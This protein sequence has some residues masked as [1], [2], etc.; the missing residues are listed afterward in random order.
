MEGDP[1]IGA[2]SKITLISRWLGFKAPCYSDTQGSGTGPV[3]L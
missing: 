3:P 2:G 1:T